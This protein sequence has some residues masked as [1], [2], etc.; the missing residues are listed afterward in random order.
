MDTA[1]ATSGTQGIFRDI[2]LPNS[3]IGPT[4]PDH[5]AS[6]PSS[7]PSGDDEQGHIGDYLKDYLA[8]KAPDDL[9][10][11]IFQI[12]YNTKN[13]MRA[14]GVYARARLNYNLFYSRD[15]SAMWEENIRPDGDQGG[16][17]YTSVGVLKNA[18][19]HLMSMVTSHRPA[20][21][22]VTVNSSEAANDVTAIA[23]AI[24]DQRLH[25]E[26]DIAKIDAGLK[27]CP[28]LGMAFHH[29]F[30]DPYAGSKA[31]M[32]PGKVP[33]KGQ[34]IAAQVLPNGQPIAP[35]VFKGDL[36]LE[37]LTLLD[38]FW[39]Q[40]VK[41]WDDLTDIVVR[42]YRNRY[43]LMVAH[44]DKAEA[45]KNAA[46]RSTFM[47]DEYLP[48]PT[49]V[50]TTTAQTPSQYAVVEVW[51]YYH[52]RTAAA[53]YGR[54]QMQLPDGTVLSSGAL[55][56]WSKE[57]PVHRMCPDPMIDSGH[58][59]A[60][61]T[62]S[63]GLQEA[64]NIGASAMLTNMSAFG[65]KLILAQKGMEVESS[66]L[67]G[68]L[69]LLEVNFGPNGQPPV[70]ALDLMGSQQPLLEMLG[71]FVGQI[72]QDTGANSI[73][74][75]DP[76]GVT[77]GVAI[78]LYQSMALQFASPYEASRADTISWWATTLIRAY[79]NNPDVER[80]VKVIGAS[81][82]TQLK[83]FYGQDL[84]GIDSFTVDP[85]NPATRTLAMRYNMAVA[86][87]Q[88]GVPIQPD[89]LVHLMKTGD[90]DSTVE[91]SEDLDA[92]IRAENE[93]LMAGVPVHV[94]PGDDPVRHA[95]GHL[96]VLA[97]QRVRTNP[98]LVQ[99]VMQHYTEHMQQLGQGDIVVK[100]A[101]GMLPMGPF[102]PADDQ[103][104]HGDVPAPSKQVPSAPP[105]QGPPPGA[106]PKPPPKG[107]APGQAKPPNASQPPGAPPVPGIPGVTG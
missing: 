43:D 7:S 33:Q 8:L 53:P 87:K 103:P 37:T 30:W 106:G 65:R 26:G 83:N 21:D 94:I 55:P 44:P 74:R 5:R 13:V 31:N 100:M 28:I 81:K 23:K 17:M 27:Q 61:T 97:N 40:S 86:L 79:Q 25:N 75:G 52:K 1:E 35:V 102:P 73:V 4:S 51:I 72:E 107:A 56:E 38:C 96:T 84:R 45:I 98:Q 70:T 63:G 101:A 14:A 9:A 18:V 104:A 32:Q 67:T 41:N 85:G 92:T 78:N 91:G 49:F 42:T 66:N 90:W 80:E 71:W 36:K 50:T 69:K 62:S 22:P 20:V 3:G 46:A 93:Q 57:F 29:A 15:G 2:Q 16:S 24:I 58:G 64:L 60:V 6:D 12:V 77:A 105:H 47:V 10:D 59:Y 34:G 54:M 99:I 89:K 88:D 68:D 82:V 48:T 76:K 11:D 19:D 95:Q 39:D